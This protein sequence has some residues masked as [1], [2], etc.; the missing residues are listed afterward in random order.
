MLLAGSN[1]NQVFLYISVGY[2]LFGAILL[3][4]PELGLKT[5]PKREVYLTH[6]QPLLRVVSGKAFPPLIWADL[7]DAV[8]EFHEKEYAMI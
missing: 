3:F 8:A 6:G 4:I 7:A 2:L 1:V 5:R